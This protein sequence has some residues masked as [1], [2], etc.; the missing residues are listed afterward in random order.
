M[1]PPSAPGSNTRLALTAGI[2][3]YVIWGLVP[4]LFQLLGR[5]GVS[6]WE[7][8]AHR[9]LWAVPAA[10]IF[11]LLSRQWAQVLA[12]FR[13]PRLLGWL[14]LSALLIAANWCVFIWA[15][16]SGRVLET[17]LGYYLNPLL[18]MAAG[19]LL[20]RERINRVGQVAIGL[21]ALGVAIQAMA[22]GH[23]P[24]VSLALAVSFG[25]YGVVRKMVSA[26][27]QT[28]LLV[29]CLILAIPSLFY[30]AWLQQGAGEPALRDPLA[31]ALVI[32]C[33]PLTAI[34]LMLFAWAARRVPLSAMGFLQFIAPTMTFIMGVMQGEAFTLARAISFGFIW[35]GAAVFAWG[36]WRVARRAGQAVAEARSA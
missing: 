25:G 36:A 28:G 30:L 19:A 27:A 35:G 12:V 14:S 18:N 7:I 3:A 5:M 21:A 34:P 4:L 6:P 16:N 11:V 20:F 31:L 10:L 26:D 22:L 8:L 33:G 9:T 17:S 24:F 2:G 32:A 23:L 13:Q 29:E 15:V 1:T